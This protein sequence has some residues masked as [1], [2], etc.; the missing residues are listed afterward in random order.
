MNGHC[1]VL[2]NTDEKFQKKILNE[3]VARLSGGIGI[4]QVMKNCSF[5]NEET[6]P[7]YVIKLSTL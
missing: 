2:Q 4:L 1:P 3:R 6:F 7:F 5:K